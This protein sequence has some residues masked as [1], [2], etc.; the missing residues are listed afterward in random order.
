VKDWEKLALN[1]S[2]EGWSWSCFARMDAK[3]RDVFVIDAQ[4][5]GKHFIVRANKKLTAFR[6]LESAIR[7]GVWEGANLR[8]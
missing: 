4:R 3:G 6:K 7:K 5:D 2:R 1:L 8:S